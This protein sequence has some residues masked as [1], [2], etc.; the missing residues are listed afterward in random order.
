MPNTFSSLIIHDLADKHFYLVNIQS[1][2]NFLV[3][4]ITFSFILYILGVL[5][6][7]FNYKNFL[8]TMMSIELMYLGAISSFVLYG[9]LTQDPRA[10]IYGLFIL[11][12]AACESAV[13]LGIII[14]L[15]RFGN[16][17]DF[18][19]YQELGG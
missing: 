5:G 16:S 13:G 2:T 1:T 6:M 9:V 14:V 10:S 12:L 11:I 3:L 18:T 19:N 17:I 15:Y 4:C 8:I 7:I